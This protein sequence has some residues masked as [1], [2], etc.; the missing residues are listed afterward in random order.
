MAD[1]SKI[2]EDDILNYNDANTGFMARYERIMNRRLRDAIISFTESFNK[3]TDEL[4]KSIDSFNKSSATLSSRIY[5]LNFIIVALTL[6]LVV[7]GLPTF[8]DA[9]LKYFPVNK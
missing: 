8:L 1:W 9:I 7:F 4:K 3:Q 5:W 6:V 2:N